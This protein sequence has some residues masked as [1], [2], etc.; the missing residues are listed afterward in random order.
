MIGDVIGIEIWGMYD[1]GSRSQL[2]VQPEKSTFSSSNPNVAS[3]DS[4][5]GQLRAV[6]AG[7]VTITATYAGLTKDGDTCR[8]RT[9][10][11]AESRPR[12]TPRPRP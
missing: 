1:N 6:G 4:G 3:V 9:E 5:T 10:I 11:L 7:D 8:S 12:P 2:F